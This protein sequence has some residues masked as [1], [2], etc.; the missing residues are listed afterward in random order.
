VLVIT[1]STT[2]TNN[3]NTS[4][5]LQLQNDA[6]KKTGS[7]EN[8]TIANESKDPAA[9]DGSKGEV[10]VITNSTTKTNNTNTSAALQLQN[11]ARKKTGSEENATIASSNQGNTSLPSTNTTANTIV[12]NH[13]DL[14]IIPSSVI[15]RDALKHTAVVH[16]F[17]NMTLTSTNTTAS[18]I[19][20]QL[21]GEMG[22]QIGK[23]VSGFGL[24]LWAKEKY[25]INTTVRLRHQNISKWMHAMKYTKA[26]FPHTRHFD[27]E[28]CNTDE[29]NYL[30]KKQVELL[31]NDTALWHM[32]CDTDSCI[33]DSLSFFQQALQRKD[34]P[35]KNVNHTISLPYLYADFFSN[36]NSILDRYYEGIRKLFA[37]DS[38]HCMAF[39]EPDESVLVSYV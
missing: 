9:L 1:N 5:A 20:V 3:T 37:F 22:N 31:G 6:R 25:G 19:V 29:F 28:E 21:S 27:F 24:Q 35:V 11:D 34:L 13:S 2:K 23:L 32:R 38:A 15:L 12:S 33:D 18:T 36:R 7:E 8:A 26:A 30:E 4:A 39:P 16:S 14:N 17:G 10:L